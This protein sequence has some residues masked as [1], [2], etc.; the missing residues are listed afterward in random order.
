MDDCFIAPKV[1]CL[2]RAQVKHKH[3]EKDRTK[4]L[5]QSPGHIYIRL[6]SRRFPVSCGQHG[7]NTCH[8]KKRS[9]SKKRRT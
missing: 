1:H 2:Q 4:T 8:E 5:A 6:R 9:S 7:G 3:E